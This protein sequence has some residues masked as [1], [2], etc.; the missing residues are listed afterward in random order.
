MH[1]SKIFRSLFAWVPCIYKALAV[2]QRRNIET[3]GC[4]TQDV[5]QMENKSHAVEAVNH[6]LTSEAGCDLCKCHFELRS[7]VWMLCYEVRTASGC[8]VRSAVSTGTAAQP[9]IFTQNNHR[10]SVLTGLRA[11][12]T[13]YNKTIIHVDEW[14]QSKNPLQVLLIEQL[15]NKP[16]MFWHNAFV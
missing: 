6:W 11:N 7:C 3:V 4:Y 2:S 1:N 15:A 12:R 9:C 8:V 5:N 16:H 10:V 14:K 13:Y